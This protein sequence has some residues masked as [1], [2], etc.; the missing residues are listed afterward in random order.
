MSALVRSVLLSVVLLA[1]LATAAHA[2]GA[3][4]RLE[5]PLPPRSATGQQ[6]P[7]PI[8]LGAVGDIEFWA[9]NRGVLITRGNPPTVPPG[10]WAYNGVEW[11]EL[12]T[13]CGA[14]EGKIAWAGP[15]E[16]WTVSDGRAGQST[17][18][19][20]NPPLKDNTLCH[21]AG[22][23]VVA[24]YAK[25][26][27]EATSYHAM[28]GAACLG[29]EDC[30]FGGEFLPEPQV[31]AFQLHWNGHAVSE[32]PN[33]EGHE[34]RSMAAFNG[35]IYQGV[36]IRKSY[37]PSEP[38]NEDRLTEPESPFEPSDLHLIN[39]EGV[40]PT[41]EQLTSATVP[42][43]T[44]ENEP[45]WSLE[46]PILGS[47]A[48][49]MWGAANPLRSSEYPRGTSAPGQQLTVVRYAEGEWRQVV[50]PEFASNPFTRFT[51]RGIQQSRA[52]EEQEAEND[53]IA[54]IAPEPGSEAAWVSVSSP[55]EVDAD[56]IA[57]E[58]ATA[59]VERLT[60]SGRVSEAVSLPSA[61]ERE[62]GVGH[63]G[64]ATKVVCPE[65]EDCWMVTANGWL[66]HYASEATRTL[67]RDGSA[68][69]A[70]LITERPKD[71]G[72]PQIQSDTQPEEELEAKAEPKENVKKPG[73][74][75]PLISGVRSRVLAGGTLE[76]TFR[77]AV[78]ARVRLVAMNGKRIVAATPQ[79]TLHAGRRSLRLK[80][81]RRHWP[82]HIELETHP[83][84]PLPLVRSKH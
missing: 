68:A 5:Q 77:L 22:G 80:L 17:G 43:Y 2:E 41:F 21:F 28:N 20:Y 40:T 10:V 63:L 3:A 49:E 30:W 32:E 75:V 72:I 11:H 12:A 56:Q 74:H 31:G 1:I 51:S 25:P 26:A 78:K 38:E 73:K 53:R 50:G 23:K 84:A 15:E 57:G 64:Q 16:F 54:S 69:F 65:A 81:N 79:R 13:V 83:L 45:S 19:G 67:E 70:S 33:P 35:A 46:A 55:S 59:R 82:K 36:Q 34:V 48:S 18:Y 29:P 24:S 27:Y 52:E 60:A 14:S 4:W 76:L 62:R 58:N 6:S 7:I 9:P 39:P 42:F 66:Y 37:D 44:Q 71:E 61:A 47:D 8:G